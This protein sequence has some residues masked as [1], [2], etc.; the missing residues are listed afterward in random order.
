MRY[1]NNN[2]YNYNVYEETYCINLHMLLCGL[3]LPHS[4]VLMKWSHIDKGMSLA[5]HLA[6]INLNP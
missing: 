3:G 4:N 6:H 5:F 2:Y 1:N